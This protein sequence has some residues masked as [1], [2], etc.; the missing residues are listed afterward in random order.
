[1]VLYELKVLA[2]KKSIRTEAAAASRVVGTP[3]TWRVRS[4]R[5]SWTI[6]KKG[7]LERSKLCQ[8]KVGWLHVKNLLEKGGLSDF[9]TVGRVD[10]HS[11]GSPGEE[12]CDA[13]VSSAVFLVGLRMDQRSDTGP[14]GFDV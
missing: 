13:G 8:C 6:S 9:S 14:G 12:Q 7:L 5:K 3:S 11:G 1:M 4:L 10:R 2:K